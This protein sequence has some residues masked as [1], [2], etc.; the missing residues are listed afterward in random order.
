MIQGTD[1][2]VIGTRVLLAIAV[3]LKTGAQNIGVLATRHA[4]RKTLKIASP[5]K[6]PFAKSSPLTSHTSTTLV[7]ANIHHPS[8]RQHPV[9]LLEGTLK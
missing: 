3:Q 9:G 8:H 4:F 7:I 6:R 1:G 5:A 2:L